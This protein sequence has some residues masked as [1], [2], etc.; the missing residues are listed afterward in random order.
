MNET[1]L[2]ADDKVKWAKMLADLLASAGYKVLVTDNGHDAI[3]LALAHRPDLL[4]LDYAMPS[5]TGKEVGLCLRKEDG[6]ENTPIIFVSAHEEP[7]ERMD[8]EPLGPSLFMPKPVN[9]DEV[10]RKIRELLP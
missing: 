3:A 1:I 4:I 6:F 7:F 10:L 2:I 5:F 9:P 8:A